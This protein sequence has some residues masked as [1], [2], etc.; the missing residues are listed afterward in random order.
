MRQI[1]L[2]V[3]NKENIMK[4]KKYTVVIFASGGISKKHGYN[5]ID[6]SNF[7]GFVAKSGKFKFIFLLGHEKHF[8]YPHKLKDFMSTTFISQPASN[9]NT[10]NCRIFLIE[11]NKGRSKI[12]TNMACVLHGKDDLRM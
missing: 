5:N 7:K 8:Q 3:R 6:F 10:A 4:L 1:N 2:L 11:A 12:S 9:R